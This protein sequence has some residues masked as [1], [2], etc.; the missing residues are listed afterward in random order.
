MQ[1][2]SVKIPITCASSA[3][4]QY[5][6]S[7]QSIKVPSNGQTASHQVIVLPKKR[8]MPE[9][10]PTSSGQH[11]QNVLRNQAISIFNFYYMQITK[12]LVKV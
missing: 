1:I 3:L 2:A 6:N 4:P 12:Q 8:L 9:A 7:L 11:A 5:S 10:H